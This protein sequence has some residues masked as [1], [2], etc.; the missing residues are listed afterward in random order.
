[1]TKTDELIKRDIV[2]HLIWDNRV[3][4]SKIGVE[5]ENGTVTLKGEVPTY[6]SKLAAES[7]A[8][9]VLGVIHTINELNVSYPSFIPAP[10]DEELEENI[11]TRLAA[12]PDINLLDMEVMV[13]SGIVTLKG[14]V[15]AYW[16]KFYAEKL[17]EP[18]PG[19]IVIENHLAVVPTEDI[20][21]Q[22]IAEDIMRTIDAKANVEAD[23][24]N[25]T[26]KDGVV[27]LT[28]T[29]PSWTARRSAFDAALYTTGVVGVENRLTVSG[30]E[31][32]F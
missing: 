2:N 28:G 23:D 15:D 9:D 11:R 21:D 1:M 31:R 17:I 8:L 13:R 22:Q 32:V 6:L 24:I 7:D 14:T 3:D 16:K 20:I 5:V 27:T 12:N 30:T 29:V 4:A 25:V 18:E 19:V 10:P 26:V